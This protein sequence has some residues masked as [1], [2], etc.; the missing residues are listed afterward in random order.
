MQG[1]TTSAWCA[2][3]ILS[4]LTNV[5]GILIKKHTKNFH[6]RLEPSYASLY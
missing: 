5:L 2:N 1:A 6:Y 3:V 4:S